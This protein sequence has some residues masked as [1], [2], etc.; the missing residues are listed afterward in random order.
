MTITILGLGPGKFDD[1]TLAAW[2]CLEN[3]TDVYLR[4]KRHPM[5]AELPAKVTYHSFDDLYDQADNFDAL[6]EQIAAKIIALA[7]QDHSVIYA[8]PGHPLVG[9]KTTP[10][11]QAKAKEKN[12]DVKIIDGL[13]FIEPTLTALGVDGMGGLQVQDALDMVE[14]YHPNI[15][16]D[17]P[18]LVA[19]VYSRD[20]ASD[21]KLTL[22][23]QYP[24]EF[25]VTLI[26]GAGT[27]DA[28]LETVPLYEIDRSEHIAHLT[29]LY[30]PAMSRES[31]FESLQN[32]VA[33]L[34]SERGCPWDQK[35]THQSLR[36]QFLEEVYEVLEAIDNEDM[37]ALKEELGDVLLHVIF[38]IQLATETQD[39]YSTDVFDYIVTKLVRRHPHV[40]GDVSVDGAKNVEAN[41]ESIKQQEE[42][43]KA[44]KGE[45]A[46]ESQLD[47]VPISLPALVFAY[48]LQERAAGVGFDWDTIE[49]V[50]AKVFEEIEEIKED[51]SLD[52]FGDLLFAVVNWA[53]WVG[54]DPESALRETNARFKRR[55]K[56]I[57]T[58]VRKLNKEMKDCSL[59]ELDKFW[60]AAKKAGL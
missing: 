39:F 41:W 59:E 48:R 1:L 9:E 54:H 31:S 13:S 12:I 46:R 20:V 5:V 57:E 11:I 10:L 4:T 53:R 19:Q 37:D 49:P 40:W 30:V 14:L 8:V 60:D 26:H 44:E 58:E 3:A 6:Y 51:P 35:Q 42:A 21:V 16:P 2:R 56:Y 36:P 52:E 7:T 25:E 33:H 22:M 18:T 27:P 24:D 47:G 34:R 55:F 32:I 28:L 15:N 29:S 17:M 50:I 38:Q 43:A 23:N 45:K